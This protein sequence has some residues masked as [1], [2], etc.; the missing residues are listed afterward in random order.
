MNNKIKS[1]R[2][3]NLL[4]M[5]VAVVTLLKQTD[6]PKVSSLML[7][8]NTTIK[9]NDNHVLQIAKSISVR[10]FSPNGLGSGVIIKR[11]F[12]TYLILTNKHV[13]S[14][15]KNEQ[16]KILTMDGKLH[17][18]KTCPSF[19][20]G[21]HDLALLEFR[22]PDPYKVVEIG[23][24]ELIKSGEIVY[25]VGFPNW[26]WV[27]DK[28]VRNTKDYGTKAFRLTRGKVE[29]LLEKPLSE[30]YQIGYTNNVQ[31]G[32]SGGAILNRS[33]QLLG[34]N[35]R[36]SY[37]LAG[38]DAFQFV[39]GTEPS[40]ALYRQMESLSWGIPSQFFRLSL[41]LCPFINQ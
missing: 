14:S 29:M 4:V 23:S 9:S 21:D 35:G 40:E 6:C 11:Y 17:D 1:F 19:I 25:A 31:H 3:R 36:S 24:S 2:F 7:S 26:E 10:I 27:S 13:V 34:I 28:A 20:F 33:G 5:S 15:N 39:D 16:Y 30:G 37:P 8:D 41:C 38:I 12:D 18:A 22:S 32:M